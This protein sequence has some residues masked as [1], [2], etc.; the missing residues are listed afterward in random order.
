MCRVQRFSGQLSSHSPFGAAI[1]HAALRP[2]ATN[3]ST[4]SYERFTGEAHATTAFCCPKS[5]QPRCASR[6][7]APLFCCPG[8]QGMARDYSEVYTTRGLGLKG[9]APARRLQ[10][11]LQA[12]PF[13]RALKAAPKQARLHLTP[14]RRRHHCKLTIPARTAQAGAHTATAIAPRSQRH[15]NAP[16][17]AA[18]Q[19]RERDRR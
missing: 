17:A 15:R 12:V 8:Y 10:R 7:A 9:L 14:S 1:P 3:S 5:L 16:R 4:V 11:W 19:A 6:R 13:C 2:G 18:R